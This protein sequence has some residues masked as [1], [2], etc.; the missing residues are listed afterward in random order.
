M[1][2]SCREQI[3]MKPDFALD[4][5]LT[6]NAVLPWSHFCSASN[7]GSRDAASAKLLQEKL[8]HY[9]DIVEVNIAHQI[10]L[11]S[12]AFFH[13][14]T[15]QHE[16]QDYL[17]KTSQAVKMLR[18]KISQ[19]DR[20][21]CE[22]S[23]RI[24]HQ[25]LTRDNCIKV[26]NKLKLMATVHQ[27][28]PTVQLLLSTSEYVGALDLIAT[29]QE[30]LQQELQGI[31]SFRH[32]GSQLCEL[33]KLID[34]MI[35]AEFTSYA[36]ST[37][38]NRSL[39]EDC[40]VIEEERLVS[41]VFGLLKQRKL[42][43]FE[44]YADEIMATAKNIIKQ[45]VVGTV[46]QI[47]EID[48]ELVTKLADQMRMMNFSQWFDLLQ[49]IFAKFTIFLQRVKA[50]INVIR[51]VVLMV[52][53]KNQRIREMERH[54]KARLQ[55]AHDHLE[56]SE[57]DWFKVLWS[58]ETKIEIFGAN[59][60]RDV[61]R[62]DGGTA[63]DPKNTIPTVKH[64]GGSIMLWGCFSAKGPGHLVRIHGKMDSTA[65]LEILAKNLRSSIKD[66]KMGRH[67]IFQQ[68]NDPKHTA[69]KTKAWFKRQK[70]KVLQ[71]PSQSPDLNPIENLWK[72][73][74]IK[75]HMRHPKNLDNLEK[76]CMEEWAKITP[77]TCA[78][79]IRSYK[80]RLLAVIANKGY[81]TKY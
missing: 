43:F 50:T 79:L 20:V 76:I 49:N 68:D 44:I 52:L 25:A 33:E 22:G 26:Y 29:T 81:S 45:C 4:D 16:L 23:L 42:D 65:Y 47:D 67:F 30:V 37:D 71:W 62:L 70:I 46:S 15:S 57:T 21:M 32:L 69:K 41:L 35:I 13:A 60:T 18:G 5:S 55:F 51:S 8:S 24:L 12:E 11:R 27:T 38:L 9:L 1:Q 64:G 63:Y 61:W 6:F 77:E 28:Q 40:Q 73:L 75:V 39:E 54:V 80:R 53:D 74:K 14:M 19:I 31:H 10:S 34:K 66:L 58:D 78:G 59:H 2:R 56:D 3:F 48:S 72:E 17:R 36:R 7:N